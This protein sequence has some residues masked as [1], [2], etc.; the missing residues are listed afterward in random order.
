MG[1]HIGERGRGSTLVSTVVLAVLVVVAVGG[2]SILGLPGKIELSVYSEFFDPDAV[3]E[4]QEIQSIVSIS[5]A[6]G[7]QSLF[8]SD[9]AGRIV[10]SDVPEGNYTVH[11]AFM[12]S[13][14]DKP[15]GVKAGRTARLTI[16]LPEVGI[17]F[18]SIN[19]QSAV[20][21]LQDP[22]VRTAL[23]IAANRDALLSAAD[24]GN[25]AAFSLI[26]PDLRSDGIT[27]LDALTEST[28]DAETLLSGTTAFS[29]SLLYNESDTHGAMAVELKSQLEALSAVDTITLEA[30]PWQTYVD[31]LT[32]GDL[33]VARTGLLIEANSPLDYLTS[34]AEICQYSSTTLDDLLADADAA[35]EASDLAG[36]AG[37]IVEIHNLLLQEMIVIPVHYR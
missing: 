17:S 6:I 3:T 16:T 32:T 20:A 10:I 5:P 13:A 25:T 34:I 12:S 22:E 26:P 9:A 18:Y 14:L 31:R 4:E 1:S 11:P 37:K 8:V 21:A 28:T 27:G 30:E 33:D 2:C 24:L 35:I 19:T 7:G 23:A 36:L 15:I 29:F